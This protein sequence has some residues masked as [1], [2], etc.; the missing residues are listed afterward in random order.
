MAI[1]VTYLN[2]IQ[3]GQEI[4]KG[5]IVPATAV[6]LVNK[7]TFTG[8][9]GVYIP[10]QQK[11]LLADASAG[12]LTSQNYQWSME[13]DVSF[14]QILYYLNMGLKKVLTGTGA[15][16]DKTYT[17]APSATGADD[18]LT[19][20]MEQRRTDGTN[21][22]DRVFS[23]GMVSSIEI[24]GAL[25]GSTT[26]KVEGFCQDE[27]STGFT[28][29]LTIPATFM[30][31]AAQ[32]WKLYSDANWAALGTTQISGQLYGFS[33]KLNTGLTAAMYMGSLDMAR[34]RRNMRGVELSLTLD[35]EMTAGFLETLKT[36]K[37][38]RALSYLQLEVLGATLGAGTY[39]IE[40]DG[41]YSA[42]D[43]PDSDDHD[44]EQFATVKLTS[45]YDTT[46]AQDIRAVVVTDAA[47]LV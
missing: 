3:V 17:F 8:Q 38:S 37:R 34:H 21:N 13:T 46:G 28:A 44:G 23:Y 31:P 10:R 20:S 43:V 36:R 32:S 26:L 40:L 41:A 5:T 1:A 7:A 27:V 16:A 12:V 29:A 11:G 6:L 18:F 2:R 15:G 25:D 4:T 45:K 9:D 33:W 47:A 22:V 35:H 42:D 14:Q 24:A 39:K 19:M 30:I